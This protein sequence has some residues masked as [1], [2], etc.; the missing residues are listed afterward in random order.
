MPPV[1]IITR[2]AERILADTRAAII[3]RHPTPTLRRLYPRTPSSSAIRGP[4]VQF[5]PLS[6][7]CTDLLEHPDVNDPDF[8]DLDAACFMMLTRDLPALFGIMARPANRK[9]PVRDLPEFDD[10][11]HVISDP[12]VVKR[13]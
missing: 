5:P 12:I 1:D 2:L 10:W 13:V 4:L 3:S 9:V 11:L 7:P 6:G 8:I